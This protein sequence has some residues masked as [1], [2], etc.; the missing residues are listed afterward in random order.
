VNTEDNYHINRIKKGSKDSFE[1]IFMKYYQ[2]LCRYAFDL[3]R[4]QD[5]AKDVVTEVFTNVWDKRKDID[6]KQSLRSYL[7]RS[8]YNR[9]LNMIRN[10]K[11]HVRPFDLYDR[12]EISNP[13]M[14]EH[15]TDFPLSGIL[16]GEK[17]EFIKSA[18]DDL[19]ERCR[20]I[21]LLHRKF[22]LKYA[23]IAQFLGL[24]EHT[25]KAQVQIALQKLRASIF[26]IKE[27]KEKE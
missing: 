12:E 3:L 11:K 27:K 14:A 7:Y 24:S 21:F 8:V 23:E 1:K 13:L 2:N 17:L 16:Q 5:D 10:R 9:S 20:Q 25:V 18:I 15:D 22:R 6:V 19:P 26:E 4:S